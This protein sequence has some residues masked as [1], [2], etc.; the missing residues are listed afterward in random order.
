MVSAAFD[1]VW[2]M[3]VLP[4]AV[5]LLAAA[6]LAPSRRRVPG[7]SSRTAGIAARVALAGVAAA[8]LIAIG[9]PLATT[10][11]VR[12]SQAA[13]N[14]SDTTAALSDARSAVALE[15]GAATPQLQEALVLELRGDLPDAVTAARRAT[16]DEPANW[17]TWLVLSRLEAESGHATAAVAAYRRAR[18]QNPRSLVFHQ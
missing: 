18:T 15:P 9:V 17:Q 2:Q 6:V 8:S 4:V 10:E 5:L 11:A 12:Q 14:A 13:V 16:A 1:W 3:P 7:P